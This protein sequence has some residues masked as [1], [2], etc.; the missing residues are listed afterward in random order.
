MI[1]KTGTVKII[2]FGSTRVA[3]ILE[4]AGESAQQRMLG[5]AQWAAPETFL[6]EPGTAQADVFSLGVIAYQMLTG[7][8]PYGTQVPKVASKAELMRLDYKSALEYRRDIPVWVDGAIRKAVHPDPR[9]RYEEASEFAWDLRHPN[10]A[11][12]SRTR[13]PLIERDPVTF[14]K[15]VSAILMAALLAL[16]YIKLGQPR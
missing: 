5:A 4:M 9:K 10:Q 8:L 2:D 13:P 15:C 11:F 14:W 16:L 3:G 7:R 12:L 1:D 6:G